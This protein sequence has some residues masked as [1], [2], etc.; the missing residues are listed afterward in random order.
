MG[1]LYGPASWTD[2]TTVLCCNLS[3]PCHKLSAF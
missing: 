1:L 3:F 2:M